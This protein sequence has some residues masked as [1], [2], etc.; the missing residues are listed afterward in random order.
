MDIW[1]IIR[2]EGLEKLGRY[3]SKYRAIVINSHPDDLNTGNLLVEIPK[4]Q[5][6][7]RVIAR[8]GN[9]QGGPGFGIKPFLPQAG[10]IVWIEF[11]YGNP[12][13]AVWH[14]HTWANGECP[15]EL[16]DGSSKNVCGIVTPKGHKLFLEESSNGDVLH[17]SFGENFTLEV[18]QNGLT[19]DQGDSHIEISSDQVA[20]SSSKELKLDSGKVTLN[21]GSQGLININV[22]KQFIQAVSA[23][24]VTAKSGTQVAQFIATQMVNL[25]DTKVVH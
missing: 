2:R 23:D 18:T 21:Q 6:G 3:Y 19:L 22:L 15:K 14:P 5:G 8:S 20:V 25:E 11:E 9:I 13:Q 1:E 7:M 24:L 16:Q 10:E 4:V 17:L 12:T